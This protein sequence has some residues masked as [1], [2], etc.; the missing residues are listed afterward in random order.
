MPLVFDQGA[1]IPF[2]VTKALLSHALAYVIAGILLG[3]FLGYGRAFFVWSSLHVPVLAFLVVNVAAALFAADSLLALYG[4]HDRMVGLGTIADGVLLY[5]AVVL[6]I[7]TRTE[8]LALTTCF[9]GSSALVLIYEAIQLAGR[10]P[11]IWSVNGAFRPFSTIGQT[12]SLAEYM[13]VV[14]IGAAALGLFMGGLGR[15]QRFLLLIYSGLALA[16]VV[17][18]ETRSAL[19]GLVTGAG[20]LV[21]LTLALHPDRLARVMS[22]LGAAAASVTLA[23]VLALTP[24]GARV[25]GTVELSAAAEGEAGARLEQSADVRVALYLMALDMVRDRPAL[26]YGPDNFLAALPAYRS[27][28][29]PAAIQQ[30]PN[31]S[32]HGWVAQVAATSGVLGLIAFVAIAIVASWLTIRT[33]FRPAAWAAFAMLGAFLGAGLTTVN[34]VGTDWLFW[35]AA[36]AVA[37]TTTR[38]QPTPAEGSPSS[39]RRVRSQPMRRG[40]W[41]RPAVGFAC[42]ALGLALAMTTVNAFDAAR[43]ARASQVARLQ[44]RSQQAIDL[45]LRATRADSLR[46]Q[47]WDTLGLAYVSGDRI[48]EAASAFERASKL[49]PYDVRYYGD[50]ARAYVV[51]TQ[52]GDAA[53]GVRAREVA[54]R[55][56]Q[57]DPNN[58][59]AHTTRAVVMQVTGN[60]PEASRSVQRALALD[61]QSMSLPLYVTA[62]Q[63]F[64]D[65]GNPAEA[66]NIARRGLGIFDATEVTAA[67]IPLRFE[68]ARALAATGQ[69]REALDEL[70]LVLRIR[71]NYPGGEQLRAA[72]R[73]GLS[74]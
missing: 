4:T 3:L 41:R 42:G 38:V 53:S 50:L 2:T 63:I 24:L 45:G 56:V 74:N 10:D 43:S 65:S 68:L 28:D 52:R 54:E 31:T 61:P 72:I 9:V 73:A 58:P 67:A 7:R 14:T 20:L 16:G 23:L 19:L 5:F 33:G 55:A 49:A 15:F 6:L 64:I 59:Q 66:V 60:L 29:E 39:S 71:P 34:G 13:T 46:A 48:R 35:A 32:A 51:L 37:A 27:E 22:L 25:L 36:G 70:D 47:Y 62:A 21:L 12:T 30:S 26:G 18:T 1:D 57:T 8:G 44:L 40:S 17:V 11:L 69:R